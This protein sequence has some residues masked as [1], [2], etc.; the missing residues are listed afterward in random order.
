MRNI[1]KILTAVI[2]TTM[3]VSIT[4]CS[5]MQRTEESKGKTVLAEVGDE[6]ITK[7]DVDKLLYSTLQS[8]KSYYGKNF[9]TNSKLKS[10]IKQQRT[11]A[12]NSLVAEK[13]L[14]AKKSDLKVK[15]T[16]AEINKSVNSSISY[17]KQYYDTEKSYKQF[18]TSVGLTEKSFKAY[19]KKQAILAKIAEAMVKDVKVTDKE[20]QD[21]YNKN[22]S[23]YVKKPGANVVH[24]VFTDETT[25]KDD[26]TAAKKLI[27][28]GKTL[29]EVSELSQFK[30]KCKYED[31]GYQEFEDNSKLVTEFVNGF[32]NLPAGQV[33]DP[34]QTSYGWHLILTSNVN[35]TQVQQ[36][37]DQVKDSVKETV[38]NNK[39]S[40]EYTE[41]LKKYKKEIGVK[42]YKDR[43]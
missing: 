27:D 3:L 33:S 31:L 29:K 17:Y 24:V 1:K 11:S 26:A 12:L 4:G 5:I 21:Y 40:A 23:S 34:V 22:T 28:E 13:V 6:K 18:V 8:Y 30:N 41:K 9:E 25:G 32:K 14:M 16:N 37:Y 7:N 43:Y 2:A 15:Y 36:T 20:C 39:K 10:T 35:S 42:I 38:L 19:W